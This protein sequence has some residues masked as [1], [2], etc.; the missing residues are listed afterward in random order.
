MTTTRS[1]NRLL[2][3]LSDADFEFLEPHLKVTQ[4]EARRSL[5]SPN[6]TIED[7]YFPETGI[8]SIVAK[9]PGDRRIEAGLIGR[10]GMT[11]LPVVMANH[12][13]PNEVYAQVDSTAQLVRSD[14]IRELMNASQ[15]ARQL[16][17]RFVSV[18]M[19]QTAHTAL[20]NGHAKIEERLARW[21][22]MAHDRLDGDEI[23]LTHEFM[24]FMLGVRRPGVTDALHILEGKGLISATRGRVR[25]LDREGL[26]STAG[27][28][29]GVPEAEY[30]RLIG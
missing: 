25:V 19:L 24:A 2:N 28:S 22:T 10:E 29:Y 5:E 8:I 26:V 9:A 12:R 30:K 21:L 18:F 13:S 17:L 11:G 23:P 27:T 7:V 16:F 14:V 3:A 6:Q 15:Q 4:I 1:R 20:A